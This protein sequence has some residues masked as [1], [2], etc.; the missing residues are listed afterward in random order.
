[1]VCRKE[2]G[3]QYK[4][5]GIIVW[6]IVPDSA[7]QT[8]L[9]DAIDRDKQARLAAAIDAIDRKNGHKTIKVAVQGTSNKSWCLKCEH[10]SKQYTINISDIISKLHSL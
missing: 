7:I 2:S 8:N 10:I 9:F 1:M 5:A 6:N 4:K 3:Y